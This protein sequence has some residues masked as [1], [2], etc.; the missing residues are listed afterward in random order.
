MSFDRYESEVVVHEN[1]N[2]A[3]PGL[4]VYLRYS[5]KAKSG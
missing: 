2:I 5:G 1:T 4:E 3:F